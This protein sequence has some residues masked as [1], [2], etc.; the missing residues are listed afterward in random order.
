MM[1]MMTDHSGVAGKTELAHRTEIIA[2][3]AKLSATKQPL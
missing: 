2:R 3:T 1:M